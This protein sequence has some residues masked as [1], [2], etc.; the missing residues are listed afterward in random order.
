MR[1]TLFVCLCFLP[2]A[3]AQQETGVKAGQGSVSV[4][5]QPVS[6]TNSYHRVLAIVPLTGGGAQ[7]D[8]IRPMFVPAPSTAL[9]SRSGIIAWQHQITDDGKMAIV[10]F[11][12]PTRAAFAELFASTDPRVKIFEVGQHTQAEIL[13]AFQQVKAAFTFS[14]FQPLHVQ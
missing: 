8:P 12:A 9:P 14:N 10:E 1:T 7:D 4:A 5:Q 6:P 13:A 2:V 3:V 11:V